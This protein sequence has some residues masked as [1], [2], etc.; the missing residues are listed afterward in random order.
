MVKL[1]FETEDSKFGLT[2]ATGFLWADQEGV[3]IEYQVSDNIFELYKSDIKEAFF[4]FTTIE[5]ISH[6]QSWWL[7]NGGRICV[8]LNSLKNTN[9]I[10][11]IEENRLIFNL[12]RKNKNKGKD[13]A[14][15][16]QLELYNY[17]LEQMDNL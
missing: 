16:T 1:K 5:E 12:K 17:R 8:S 14:V 11:F 9:D 4:P 7:F 3:R 10:P 6:K 2:K 13:F 15:N